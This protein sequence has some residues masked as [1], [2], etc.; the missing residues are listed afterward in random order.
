MP[1]PPSPPLPAS[2][3]CQKSSSRIASSRC[4]CH[5]QWCN[6]SEHRHS[7]QPREGLAALQGWGKGHFVHAAARV[8]A[9]GEGPRRCCR[10]GRGAWRR[11]H[12]SRA[13]RSRARSGGRRAAR[14]VGPAAAW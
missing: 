4:A 12:R 14:T 10:R 9:A 5:G 2:K 7:K 8:A 13:D 1:S 6:H 3:S 11:R